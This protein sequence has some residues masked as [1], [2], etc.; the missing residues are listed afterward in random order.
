MT[1]PPYGCAPKRLDVSPQCERDVFPDVGPRVDVQRWSDGG[2]FSFGEMGRHRQF[3]RQRFELGVAEMAGP[4]LGHDRRGCEVHDRV[5]GVLEDSGLSCVDSQLPAM[6]RAAAVAR[7]LRSSPSMVLIQPPSV[8]ALGRAHE[9]LQLGRKELGEEEERG[10]PH[11]P[12]DEDEEVR[13]SDVANGYE[14]W[15]GRTVP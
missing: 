15:E 7:R 13:P 6:R 8:Q 14:T 11:V 4:N 3:S 10:Q 5:V 9:H 2:A 12:L 1:G